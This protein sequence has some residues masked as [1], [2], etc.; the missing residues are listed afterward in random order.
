MEQR[1][2]AGESA[3]M[4]VVRKCLEWVGR[5]R[6]TAEAIAGGAAIGMLVAFTPTI[7]LQSLIALGLA[8]LLGANRP[9]AI[10]PTWLTNPLTIPPVF[11]V[12]YYIGSLVWPGPAVSEVAGNLTRAAGE[13][14]RLD[15]FSLRE[16]LV[17]FLDLGRDVFI[18]LWLGGL[19]VGAVAAAITYPVTLHTVQRLRARRAERRR[20]Q[21]QRQR[22]H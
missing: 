5:L 3:T 15:F 20:R 2:G 10:V 1:G 19:A 9:I 8:T 13:L 22:Q 18:A 16:H 6:G 17:V 7:G 21:A 12:T 14:A 4:R 11:A